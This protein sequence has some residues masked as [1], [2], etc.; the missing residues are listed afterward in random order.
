MITWQGNEGII[1][2]ENTHTRI[3][4]GRANINRWLDYYAAL[5][6]DVL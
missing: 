4:G 3:L 6:N 5:N 1:L 2:Q